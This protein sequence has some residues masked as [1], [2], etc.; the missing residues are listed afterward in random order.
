MKMDEALKYLSQFAIAI[1]KN[2]GR[3]LYFTGVLIAL[4]IVL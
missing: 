1:S 3:K 2:Y 4:N